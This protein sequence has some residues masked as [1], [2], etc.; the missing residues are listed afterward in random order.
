[1]PPRNKKL[2]KCSTV[3]FPILCLKTLF[4]RCLDS[5]H[6]V[7]FLHSH[8]QKENRRENETISMFLSC[9]DRDCIMSCDCC[10]TWCVCV[11]VHT[12]STKQ[13]HKQLSLSLSF[14]LTHSLSIQCLVL[15]LKKK[16][17]RKLTEQNN[18]ITTT[19]LNTTKTGHFCGKNAMELFSG[20]IYLPF[21]LGLFSLSHLVGWF[22]LHTKKTVSLKN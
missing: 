4:F 8:R 11:C 21:L 3:V 5:H 12:I 15:A 14:T 22:E 1:M 6:S 17:N 7:G 9:Y 18:Q 20:S 19:M 10:F 16:K 2:V 13:W